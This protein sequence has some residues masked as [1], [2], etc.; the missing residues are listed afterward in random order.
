MRR[1]RGSSEEGPPSGTGKKESRWKTAS[2]GRTGLKEEEEEGASR[3]PR[4]F[5][6]QKPASGA[7]DDLGTLGPD[8]ALQRLLGPLSAPP[9]RPSPALRKAAQIQSRIFRRREEGARHLAALLDA[10]ELSSSDPDSVLR[11]SRDT[12]GRQKDPP[13]PAASLRPPSRAAAYSPSLQGSHLFATPSLEGPSLEEEQSAIRSLDE[14]FSERDQDASFAS[15]D[16]DFRVNVLSLDDLAPA[17]GIEEEK[18]EEEESRED[19][20]QPVAGEPWK[21]P[22]AASLTPPLAA[23]RSIFSA[24]KDVVGRDPPSEEEEGAEEAGETEISER[25]GSPSEAPP[26]S[27]GSPGEAEYLDDFEPPS[28][29]STASQSSSEEGATSEESRSKASPSLSSQSCS[30]S[31]WQFP[32]TRKQRTTKT[33]DAAVQTNSLPPLS[34][35]MHA[36]IPLIGLALGGGSNMSTAPIGSPALSLDVIEGL[37]GHSPA[38]FALNEMLKE[39][40]LFIRH[41]SETSRRLHASLV[42]SLEE[43]RYHYHTLEEAKMYIQSHKAQPLTAEPALLEGEEQEVVEAPSD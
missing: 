43:E 31:L 23:A 17:G 35:W 27:S 32:S 42:A 24:S 21:K 4:R 28:S 10:S 2:N 9:A 15:S 6:K 29:S 30:S 41:Y 12:E 36:D 25:L 18:E 38:A 5:L 40:L 3:Q 16:S 7:T 26:S 13:P 1:D 19:Q 22:D 39:N 37:A 20:D 33:M 34:Q 14:L 11:G 8:P